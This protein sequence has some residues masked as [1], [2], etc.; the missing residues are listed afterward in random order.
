MAKIKYEEIKFQ[1][2]KL[3]AINLANKIIEDYQDQGYDLTLRQLFYAFVSKGLLPN[4]QRMYDWLGDVIADG[5]LAGLVDWDAIVDRG[6]AAEAL[7][8]WAKPSDL[9]R[10]FINSFHMDKWSDQAHY[11]EVYVEKD[12]LKDI[13]ATIC[14][15]LDVPYLS[16]R[17]YTSLTALHDA[18]RRLA[19]KRA[20]G[21][22]IHV[23]H[24]GDH[25]PSGI[26]MSRNIKERLELFSRGSVHVLRAALNM[27]Q[28]RQ[29][30][31]PPNPAKKTDSRAKDYIAKYGEESWELDALPPEVLTDVIRRA[32]SQYRDETLW[33]A[34]VEKEKKGRNTLKLIAD[35]FAA[36][37]SYVVGLPRS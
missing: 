35:N 6:R 21:K 19:K 12:A 36:V 26:D 15:R 30:N 31:L 16:C 9:L 18:G 34:A 27:S 33:N 23:I 20:Q 32:V 37:V 1:E 5:R 28:V 3:R 10:S 4:T 17:G 25:D 14:N 2:I 22:I 8:H 13:V 24:L 29:Y 7:Q 11:V